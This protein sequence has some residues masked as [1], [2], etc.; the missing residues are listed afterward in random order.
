MAK[1]KVAHISELKPGQRKCVT[2][3]GR[4]IVLFNVDGAYF[5]LLN[6]C[7]HQGA[8]LGHG[9]VTGEVTSS[10]PGQYSFSQSGDV[11]RCPWHGWEFRLKTGESWFDPAKTRV[12]TYE[13]SV[14]PEDRSDETLLSVDVFEVTSED[15]Y[16]F[17][18]V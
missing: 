9:I 1:Y 13:T 3:G 18:E 8:P 6:R 15:Q 5:A 10:L 14:G 2:A 4:P 12:R 17:V 16:I 11:L 7:P